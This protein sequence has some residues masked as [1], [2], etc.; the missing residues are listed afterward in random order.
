MMAA[1][2][3]WWNE[4]NLLDTV[5]AKAKGSWQTV[6]G[7][8]E[9]PEKI[10]REAANI[11]WW[12]CVQTG[13]M[14]NVFL[15]TRD[16]DTGAVKKQLGKSAT[17][18]DPT[19]KA[20][21]EFASTHHQKT[22]LI[23]Y[24]LS[25]SATTVG[26]VMGLNSVTDYWDTEQH[27]YNDPLRGQ[28]WEGHGEP[29]HTDLMPYQDYACRIQGA[30]LHAV[31]VNFTAAWN[32]ASQQGGI[33]AARGVNL[34][35]STTI[36]DSPPKGLVIGLKGDK[37]AVQIVRT[38]PE[39]QEEFIKDLY[40]Q[41]SSYARQY[42]YIENQYFQYTDWAK[43]LKKAR[44]AF[45]DA[46]Q[47]ASQVSGG[48]KKPPLPNL[49]LI[50]VTPTPEKAQMIPR[51]SDTLKELGQGE[52]L[53]NQ[54]QWVKSEIV[55]HNAKQA[56]YASST[57]QQ[58][59][60]H[61]P[62]TLSPIAQSYLDAG[63]IDPKTNN[64]KSDEDITTELEQGMGLKVLTA[65]L[66]TCDQVQTRE[67]YIHS[68][69]MIIDDSMYTIGSANLNLRS[70]SVDSEINM[71]TD[72]PEQSRALRTKVWTMH[73]KGTLPG[74]SARGVEMSTTFRKWEELAKENL[75][76]KNKKQ[77]LTAFLTKFED[78]RVAFVRFA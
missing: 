77:Q 10:K 37:Q 76:N 7:A 68:K 35:R 23:D 12:A 60:A 49:H 72:N 41:A 32:K 25:G 73:T 34:T 33:A 8:Q 67:I 9:A 16:G 45:A 28:S 29:A 71:V 64:V 50:V 1:M 54:N 27:L 17:V 55:A 40:A 51:T 2:E 46:Y 4:T 62:P 47:S 42:I 44:Q 18:P 26:Y 38:Q 14:K 39:Y 11:L 24:E 78:K 75:D 3:H 59:A 6:A 31:S 13:S 36:A 63:A 58:Q 52:S 53:P 66:F 21:L 15:R 20:L 19:E 56:Q 48:G 5:K 43:A 30:A 74:G 22:I 65:S 69:L 57:A 70:M 61:P